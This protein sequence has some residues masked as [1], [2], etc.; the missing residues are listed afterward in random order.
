MKNLVILLFLSSIASVA[1]D[2]SCE[3]NLNWLIKTVEEN[4]A[5]FQ[6]ILNQKGNEAYNTHNDIFKEKVKTFENIEDCTTILNEWTKFFRNAHLSVLLAQPQ[7]PLTNE[8][9]ITKYSG[10]ETYKIPQ[11][12][13][14]EYVAKIKEPTFEG[15]WKSGIYKI[16]ILKDKSSTEEKYIGFIIK[17]DGVYWTE[18]QVKLEIYKSEG[19]YA[20]DFILRNHTKELS[21]NVT[22]VEKNYITIGSKILKRIEPK[23][24]INTE[25][26]KDF[27][28]LSSNDANLIE[29]SKETM[30]LR[31]PSFAMLAKKHLD[32]IL[33]L[34]HKEIVGHKNLIID[35]RNNSGGSGASD[36]AY[37]NIIPYIYTNPIE[38]V[39]VQFLSTPL[40]NK[41]MQDMIDSP[42]L[43]EPNKNW[44]RNVLKKLNTNLGGFV[45]INDSIISRMTL[46]KVYEYPKNV[47]V[48]TNDKN[49]S[50]TEQFLIDAK[51][52]TKV[53][54]FGT[55]T[56]GSIDIAGMHYTKFPC[57]NLWLS[58]GI[59]KSHRIPNFKIDGRGIQ[60]DYF[61][62]ESIPEHKWI[63]HTKD[64]LESSE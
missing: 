10:R 26:E 40:N 54:L 30:L 28:L 42:N 2:C 39:D 32:S 56:S 57:D 45:D 29:L 47:A 4:D 24:E 60:P 27:D 13:F 16:G 7:V 17:A 18:G 23:F 6:H 46:D 44:A 37:Q 48:L 15:I 63:L 38:I 35:V 58:Y 20:A 53:K 21:Q 62:H 11:K 43:P 19:K 59:S 55:T 52:S 25:V 9:I 49:K 3:N 50:T 1:Q 64:I 5:G 41:R 12:E 8:E 34:N 61:I 31:I 14:S 33:T 51:Q 22:L 36:Q